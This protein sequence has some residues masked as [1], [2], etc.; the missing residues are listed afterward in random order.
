MRKVNKMELSLDEKRV[1]NTLF[2][3]IKGTT[4]NEMLCML[5][6]A[7]PEKDGSMDC[8]KI[9]SIINNLILKVFNAEPE[10]MN[11]VFAQIPFDLTEEETK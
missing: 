1:L 6:A 9:I 7:K 2:K 5:Y 11:D 10:V 3:D 4:R 8:D